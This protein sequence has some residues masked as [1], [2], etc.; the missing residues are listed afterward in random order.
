MITDSSGETTHSFLSGGGEMGELIRTYNWSDSVIGPIDN[1]PQSLCTALSFLLNS[2]FPMFLW[3]GSELIQFYNDGYRPSL[4]NNG[5]HP[6]ALGQRGE[7]CW[8]EIWTDIKPMI[9][10]VLLFGKSTWS[11][12]RLLPIY[13]NGKMEDVYWTFSHSPVFDGDRIAGVLVTCTETTEKVHTIRKLRQSQ[14]Q[15][16]FTIEAAELATWDY[17]LLTRTMVINQR[18][19]DWFGIPPDVSPEWKTVIE[20]VAETDRMRVSESIQYALQPESGGF[21]NTEYTICHPETSEE[22]IV[23]AKGRT[24]F[25]KNNVPVRFNG[26]LQD[27]TK[28]ATARRRTEE[29]ELFARSIIENS[30]VAQVVF[31]GEEMKITM[32]N[33]RMLEMLGRDNSII[34]RSF[35]E[36]MPGVAGALEDRLKQVFTTGEPYYQPE[37]RIELI[38]SGQ[39]YTGYYNYTYQAIRD[40]TGSI[41]GIMV[42]AWELTEQVLVRQKIE[43]EKERT[44]IAIAAGELGVFEVDLLTDEIVADDRFNQIYGF[45]RTMMRQDYLATCHPDDLEKRRAALEEG[46]K[47]GV[48]Q[49]E[50]RSLANATTRWIKSKGRILY[51]ANRKPVKL[52]GVVQDITEQKIFSESLARQVEERTLELHRSNEDLMQF[53]HVASHDLKEPVRKVKTF[54]GR[55]QDEF[56]A[57][58]SE[59]ANV[60]IEKIRNA[61]DRM[62]AMIDGVLSYSTLNASD[63]KNEPVDL[64]LILNSIEADLEVMIHQ[65]KA[66]L[67]RGSLPVIEGSAVLIYQLFY[68]LINN[69]LKFSRAGTPALIRTHSSETTLHGEPA[70]EIVVTDNGIG[71]NPNHADRIFNAFTRLNSKDM[72]EGTGL[73]LALCKK[74]AERH[75]GRISADGTSNIGAIFTIVLPYR[76]FK[77]II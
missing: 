14:E 55:L 47:T 53:A 58:L 76:Q 74:I 11:E 38:R 70:A 43:E 46:I 60:Y 49:Y 12:D 44:N 45:E 48:F 22:R 23:H 16:E 25:D 27:V 19:K 71:I 7:D 13:R 36:V 57:A 42:T 75:H 59:K 31:T 72:Y 37:E 50:A 51:D 61:T 20:S 32:I 33:E 8:Q 41:Y 6:T 68:N 2:R 5:K 28:E 9:D 40:L 54:T 62:L 52:F 3:W 66:T 69:S 18:M 15:L 34:G 24:W 10:S 1:W 63:Q 77:K 73:G 39:P 67:E 35:Y 64:N 56:G 30:P 65:Q 21:Y 26:T 4:G 17:N 29:S